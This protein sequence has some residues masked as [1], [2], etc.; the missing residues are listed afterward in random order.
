MHDP[1]VVTICVNA[2]WLS[3]LSYY[4]EEDFNPTQFSFVGKTA[5]T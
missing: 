2:K 4:T 1:G 3:L 5:F